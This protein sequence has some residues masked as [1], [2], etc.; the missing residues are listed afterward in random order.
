[1]Q[2]YRK[3]LFDDNDPWTDVT[4]AVYAGALKRAKRES[5]H[6]ARCD[7]LPVSALGHLIDRYF[8]NRIYKVFS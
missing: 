2:F 7:P 6:R 3:A 8:L 5:V 4:N 1:M